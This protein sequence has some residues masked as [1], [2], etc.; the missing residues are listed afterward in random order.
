MEM[1]RFEVAPSGLTTTTGYFTSTSYL[2]SIT[3]YKRVFSR[4]DTTSLIPS[5]NYFLIKLNNQ[6][7]ALNV[8]TNELLCRINAHLFQLESFNFKSKANSSSQFLLKNEPSPELQIHSSDTFQIKDLKSSQKSLFLSV[9]VPNLTSPVEHMVKISSKSR[10]EILNKKNAQQQQKFHFALNQRLSK[11]YKNQKKHRASNNVDNSVNNEDASQ[12]HEYK[13]SDKFKIKSNNTF[14]NILKQFI[15][16]QGDFLVSKSNMVANSTEKQFNLVTKPRS[17]SVGQ[18]LYTETG[19]KRS[20]QSLKK[21]FSKYENDNNFLK[22][23]NRKSEDKILQINTDIHY[24]KMVEIDV[25]AGDAHTITNLDQLKIDHEPSANL[26]TTVS[27]F[28]RFL[29][30]THINLRTRSL[31]YESKRRH[32]SDTNLRIGESEAETNNK[33]A[34]S[35]GNEHDEKILQVFLSK[36]RYSARRNAICSRIDKLYHNKQLVNYME[37][38]LREDYIKNFLL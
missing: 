1:Q 36:K 32:L 26:Q 35:V 2:N 24:D 11:I 9:S 16:C 3:D 20:R 31:N 15:T 23:A 17:K 27:K 37:F 34:R 25:P 38:L 8:D 6:N 14:W 29:K 30:L 19:R 13:L 21:S 4:L 28:E 10:Y 33:G 12:A 5:L 22:K 18:L 7:D